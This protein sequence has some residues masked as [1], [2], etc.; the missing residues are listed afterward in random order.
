VRRK[1]GLF[2]SMRWTSRSTTS[3]EPIGPTSRAVHW[4]RPNGD[5][6]L[7]ASKL[8]EDASASELLETLIGGSQVATVELDIK[9]TH[10]ATASELLEGLIGGQLPETV[11]VQ[12]R[13]TLAASA[14]KLLEK[15]IGRSL[16]ETV[17]VQSR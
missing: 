13:Q 15:L 1:A 10:D 8:T 2:V 11:E 5:G 14:S 4:K 9:L 17:E 3:G 16:P 6:E 7:N 12:S